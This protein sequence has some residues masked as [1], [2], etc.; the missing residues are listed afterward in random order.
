MNM[1]NQSIVYM[2]FITALLFAASSNSMVVSTLT[3]IGDAINIF[4]D[5]EGNQTQIETGAFGEVVVSTDSAGLTTNIERDLNGNPISTILPSGTVIDR[6]FDSKGNKISQTNSTLN[7]TT[8]FSFD[9]EFNQLVG[10]TSPLSTVI[11][12]EYDDNH[13]PTRLLTPQ[14]REVTS[15]FLSDGLLS[16]ATDSLG[17]VSTASYDSDFYLTNLTI[18]TGLDQRQVSISYTSAGYIDTSTDAEGRAIDLDYDNMGRVTQISLPGEREVNYAYDPAGNLVSLTP[19]G[20][21]AYGFSY[22]NVGLLIAEQYPVVTSG[23]SN[24]SSFVYNKTRN[25]T[26][27]TTADG[28]EINY[29]YDN[30]ARVT[31]ITLP[32]GMYTYDY[33]DISG[34][35]DSISSPDGITQGF[36]YNGD[37]IEQVSWSGAISGS[38]SYAYD[39]KGI[40]TQISIN[41]Q[42]IA[43]QYNLDEDITQAGLE[44]LSYDQTSG[45]LTG[46]T[47]GIIEESYLYNEF[48]ELTQHSVLAD[49]V[50]LYD[51]QYSRDKL[52][53]IS[54]KVET[55]GGTSVTTDYSYD[56]AGRL[57][58]VSEN[59]V[60]V[61]TYSYDSN[62]NR[63]DN[64]ASYD[65]QDRLI[66]DS[67]TTYA[68]TA[69]GERTEKIEGTNNTLYQYDGL[70]IL[71]GATLS[72]G[73][74]IDYLLDGLSRRVARKFNDSTTQIWLYGDAIN[75]VAQ[76]DGTNQIIQKYIYASRAQVPDYIDDDSKQYKVISDHLGSVRL[77]VDASDGSILQRI[78]YDP[79]G[80]IT[81][82]TNPDFQPFAYAGGLLDDG[83]L[84]THFG[85]R[86]YDA[87]SARWTGKDPVGFTG[88]LRNNYS[89]VFANP[90]NGIDPF[91]LET[92]NPFGAGQRSSDSNRLRGFSDQTAA[93]FYARRELETF[94][95]YNFDSLARSASGD[96]F[97][98][99]STEFSQLNALLDQYKS[100]RDQARSN[101]LYD[102]FV[103]DKIK[104]GSNKKLCEILTPEELESVSDAED[105]AAQIRWDTKR[106]KSNRDF[107]AKFQIINRLANG[108]R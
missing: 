49:S 101:A 102:E 33:N 48:A 84:F 51:V 44:I 4:I 76:L 9:A 26:Q 103:P 98:P 22:N 90:V 62:D 47:L 8:Q 37:L 106:A 80:V 58:T 56:L 85:L 81:E 99:A 55:I 11:T 35:L 86:E 29:S 71:K 104:P 12:F 79:W 28:I 89:Y 94:Y 97:N 66:S 95:G 82:N 87:I 23:G 18:G 96:P 14:G 6:S 46:T 24:Q 91:G 74:Q 5:A 25:L 41:D 31:N 64:G 32:G 3:S 77:V 65:A 13:N 105:I 10:V 42:N 60:L 57:E 83:T 68:H 21:T 100:A 38:I 27:V 36:S 16:S 61:E 30:L 72:N 67:G 7:G 19:P 52:G 50:S 59:S 75:P 40:M 108:R 78:D 88:S 63:T 69:Q 34:L 53:R 73:D 107:D 2:L 93:E 1:K 15:S 70:G 45:L 92:S 43:Y 54:R 39:A 20:K 17:T